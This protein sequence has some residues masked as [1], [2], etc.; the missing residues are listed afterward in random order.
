MTLGELIED[1]GSDAEDDEAS[2]EAFEQQQREKLEQER[3]AILNNQTLIAE[4]IQKV[5]TASINS[6][7]PPCDGRYINR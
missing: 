3:Q 7:L 6:Q 4:V 1:S 2:I 5:S